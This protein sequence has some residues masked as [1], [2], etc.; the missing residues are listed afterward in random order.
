MKRGGEAVL[1]QVFRLRGSCP[2]TLL[3]SE[4]KPELAC[5]RRD[6][7]GEP[8]HACRGYGQE[9]TSYANALGISRNGRAF[10]GVM[11]LRPY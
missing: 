8:A 10:P 2:L 7:S 11:M 5:S 1:L 3:L 6:K 9:L 4:Q